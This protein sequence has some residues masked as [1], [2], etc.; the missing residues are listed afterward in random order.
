MSPRRFSSS[1]GTY[2]GL[3]R[4]RVER[5][6]RREIRLA[7]IAGDGPLSPGIFSRPARLGVGDG[8][9]RR[10]DALRECRASGRKR[11]DAIE[12]EVLTRAPDS[13][14][15]WSVSLREPFGF[16]LEGPFS[17]GDPGTGTAKTESAA[18][19]SEARADRGSLRA[20]ERP[21]GPFS[22]IRSLIGRAGSNSRGGTFPPDGSD[23]V[24]LT[25]GRSS[26]Q[27]TPSGSPAGSPGAEPLTS[28]WKGSSR[29]GGPARRSLRVRP[30]R[31][32]DDLEAR[33]TGTG[34]PSIVGPATWKAALSRSSDTTSS[35]RDP[36]RCGHQ[37]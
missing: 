7:D 16:R 37:P 22:S 14:L 26:P 5:R 17:L 15:A 19:P 36:G 30:P 20:V 24:R 33:I 21:R 34:N 1:P 12:G 6:G 31:R 2:R 13:R 10:R 25:G 9:F 32:D 27:G 29:V 3:F 11:G 8:S 35:S 4:R 28:A 18:S 23:G